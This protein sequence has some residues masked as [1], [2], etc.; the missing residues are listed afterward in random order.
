MDEVKRDVQKSRR[1]SGHVMCMGEV[2]IPKEIPHTKMMAKRL[3]GRRR[4]SWIDQIIKYTDTSE[5]KWEEIRE[6]RKWRIQTAG[7]FSVI[8]NP[9]LLK[10]LKNDDEDWSRKN[11]PVVNMAKNNTEKVYM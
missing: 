11:T 8:F 9:Y 6:N 1:L 7:D 2:R 4:T 10:R 3:A 5:E